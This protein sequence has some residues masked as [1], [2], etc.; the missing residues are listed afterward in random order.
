MRFWLDGVPVWAMIMAW[1]RED[2]AN[3]IYTWRLGQQLALR[4]SQTKK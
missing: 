4:E 3:P 1:D 2:R